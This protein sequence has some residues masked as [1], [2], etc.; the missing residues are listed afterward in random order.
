[1]KKIF[2]LL[3]I[4]S[5]ATIG[6]AQNEN[7]QENKPDTTRFNIGNTEFIII[8]NDT[9]RVDDEGTD[10]EDPD[11]KEGKSYKEN[12]DLAYWSGFEVGVNMLMNNQFQPDFTEEHLKIDPASSFTYNF[13][14]LE[15]FIK[16]GTPHVGLVTGAGFT[17]SRYGLKN[18]YAT[19]YANSD[20][21]FAFLDSS[22]TGGYT[23]NQLRVS[24]FTVPLLLQFNT[25]KYKKK[26]FHVAVGVIG[27]VRFNSKMKYEYETTEGTAKSKV[28]GRYNVNPFQAS[29]TARVG[30]RNFGVFAN[31][32]M[33]P[34]FENQASR[35]AKPL[36]FGA[37]LHF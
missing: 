30:F 2:T 17:N 21:T 11:E 6:L 4:I 36:T 26:N 5:T 33:L 16:L 28:K 31:F 25:S 32:D 8:N 29:L 18:Q 35:V 13:N 19:L 3:A 37:C 20:T 27:G 10:F 22:I 34:L 15:Y 24:Y 14:F 23:R 12:T 1:M 9:I 7:S